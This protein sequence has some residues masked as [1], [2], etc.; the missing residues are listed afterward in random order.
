MRP[1]ERDPAERLRRILDAHAVLAQVASELGPDLDLERV[2]GTV[3][4]AM[5][6]LVD[7]RGGTVQL[8]DERGV[9]IAYADPPVDPEVRAL[10][11]PVGH[12][13]SGRVIA[14]GQAVL[15][16]DLDH[17]ERVIPEARATGSNAQ[18]RSYLAVPLVC[19]GETIGALQIDAPVEDAFDA[20]DMTLL[21]GL[22]AQ[23]AA[24]IESARRFALI[25]ELERLKHDFVSRVSH[26]LRTPLTIVEGFITMMLD[27]DERLDD[28]ERR[29]MLTRCRTAT[30]R[31]DQLIE[32]LIMLARFETG[33]VTV[34]AKPASMIRL[35][36]EV[37]DAAADPQLISIECSDTLTI[38]LDEELTRRLLGLLVDNA[39][40]YGGGAVLRVAD[41][42]AWIDI[43]DDGPGIAPDV[44][45]SIFELFTRGRGIT[46]V[47]GLGLGLPMARALAAAIGADLAVDDGPTRGTVVR[48]TLASR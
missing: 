18:M 17:D 41:N 42:G 44:K 1:D 36:D 46:D 47:P 19:L 27:Y 6:K 48:L 31:L 24:I 7:F 38:T 33:V 37:R 35:L 15:S 9:Y 16:T 25:V 11:I 10:R 40:K 12:G 8:V 4:E 2:L 26:E 30:A 29:D 34:Q 23:V 32:E 22:A 14:A 21:E 5:R 28:D 45:A 13:L 3:I 43:I 20:D 39:L